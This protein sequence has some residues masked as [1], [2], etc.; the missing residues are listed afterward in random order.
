[1][2]ASPPRRRAHAAPRERTTRTRAVRQG[3]TLLLI[4]AFVAGVSVVTV[5][6]SSALGAHGRPPVVA[7]LLAAA[8]V[9]VA[10][11]WVRP[12]AERLANWAVLR[13]RADAY[14]LVSDFVRSS[15]STLPI[16]EVLPRLAETA[17][18]TVRS[19][20]GEVRVWLSDGGEWREAWP[21]SRPDGATAVNVD[22][23]HEGRA[24]GELEVSVSDEEG[25]PAAA[26]RRLGALVGPAGLALSTVRLT[27]DL[28]R[29]LDELAHTEA[30]LR[31]SQRRLVQ[32][33][34]EE[35]QRFVGAI[36]SFVQP[37][38]T[39]ATDALSS[40]AAAFSQDVNDELTSAAR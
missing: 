29:R 18:R 14:E 1:M 12:T 40:A 28:R 31:A 25:G 2:Q 17:A 8:V 34:L 23:R 24:V 6:I 9:T 35:R 20:R 38:L 10:L 13:D 3:L 7:L 21:V 26:R 36:D 39:A 27:V 33:R 11:P 5:G 37:H 16:E 30:E 32:A 22:V 15:A 19:P 4:T